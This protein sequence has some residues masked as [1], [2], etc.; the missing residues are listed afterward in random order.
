MVF[1]MLLLAGGTVLAVLQIGWVNAASRAEEERARGALA[2]GAARV[3]TEAEDEVRVLLS[4]L[5]VSAR[6][7]AG[8]DWTRA[9]EATEFWYQTARFPSLLR[10][11]YIVRFPVPD[12]ALVYSRESSAFEDSPLPADIRDGVA[13]TQERA[14]TGFR[15]SAS[16]ELADGGI[17]FVLPAY[18]EAATLAA[19]SPWWWIRTSCTG[20][21]SLRSWSST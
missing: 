19:L 4:L 6:D 8:R 11:A 16:K 10:A 5:R 20:R 14:A 13:A 2:L 3:R 9:V 12:S 1:A 21:H 7:L 18:S 17:L 15:P